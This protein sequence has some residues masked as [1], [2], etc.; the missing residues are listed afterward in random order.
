C[1]LPR[2]QMSISLYQQN[3]TVLVENI[4]GISGVCLDKVARHAWVT[5]SSGT[6]L[7]HA[8]GNITCPTTTVSGLASPTSCVVDTMYEQ[9][10]GPV[11]VCCA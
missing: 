2:M 5:Q 4:A 8:Y 10:G 3:A 11:K 6:L 1:L 7:C 9:Y